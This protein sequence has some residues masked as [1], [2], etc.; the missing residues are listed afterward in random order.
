VKEASANFA[1]LLVGND[2]QNFSAGANLMLV[3]LE[4]QEGNWDEIDLMVRAFQWATMALK[5]SPV[6]VVAAPAGLALGGGC[7]ICLHS[8][9]VRAAA[10]TYMGLVETGV[11]LLPAGGGTKEMLMRLPV[12]AAFETIGFATV[13]TS[14]PDARRIGY[15]RDEDGITMNRDRLLEDAKRDV[16]TLSRAGY[17]APARVETIPVGG[18]DTLAMLSLGVH[19]AHRAGRISDHDA[20]IGRLVARVLSGGEVTHRTTVTE[21]QLLDLERE[22]FLKLCGERKTLERMSY[23]LKTGRTLRN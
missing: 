19:L 12:Q 9:R 14:G 15:L 17:Q 21:Q 16:L 8:S 6:P 23:T 3:L 1:A 11:G 7:E 4:A 5:Y 20:L 10:E 13:S 22:A 2:A 18:P